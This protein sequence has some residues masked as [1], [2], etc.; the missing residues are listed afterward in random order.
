[1]NKRE[2]ELKRKEFEY[3]LKRKVEA[4]NNRK[5]RYY[6]SNRYLNFIGGA[7]FCYAIIFFVEFFIFPAKFIA[8]TT[9]LPIE[10]YG[11][12]KWSIILTYGYLG[13]TSMGKFNE[14][15]VDFIS[16]FGR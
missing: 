15:M 6:T 13:M 10:Y 5:E 11:L 12:L 2:E 1:M 16:H 8:S 9:G 7:T 4:E 14:K 3:E